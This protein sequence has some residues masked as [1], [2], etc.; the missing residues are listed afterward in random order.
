MVESCT[1][2]LVFGFRLRGRMMLTLLTRGG[3][4][5]TVTEELAKQMMADEP[6]AYVLLTEKRAGK[7][8]GAP[9]NKMLE[10]VGNK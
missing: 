9:M 3:N 7:L 2:Q 5:I 8:F 6:G 1:G 10:A 4:T